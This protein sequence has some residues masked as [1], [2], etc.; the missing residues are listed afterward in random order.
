[1]KQTV[2]QNVF[3][4]TFFS[5]FKNPAP[6]TNRQIKQTGKETRTKKTWTGVKKKTGKNV[7]HG[8]LKNRKTSWKGARVAAGA[9]AEEEGKRQKQIQWIYDPRSFLQERENQNQNHHAARRRD[10]K[11]SRFGYSC[12]CP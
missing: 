1:M 11:H 3:F 2:N 4:F 8:N 9:E 5:Y 7:T 6:Q 10:H 12:G